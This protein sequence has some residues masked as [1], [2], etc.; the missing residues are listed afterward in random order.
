[1]KEKLLKK[2]KLKSIENDTQINANNTDCV[3]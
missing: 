1:M 2:K 3:I